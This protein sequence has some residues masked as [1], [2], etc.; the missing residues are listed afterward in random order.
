M[1]LILWLGP[2]AQTEV[3]SGLLIPTSQ[4][5]A[6]VC[7]KDGINNNVSCLWQ[8][9][10]GG[11]VFHRALH[12]RYLDYVRRNYS[13]SPL[14]S[15]HSNLHPWHPPLVSF[16]SNLSWSLPGGRTLLLLTQI[17]I[18]ISVVVLEEFIQIFHGRSPM[19]E[20]SRFKLKTQLKFL[21]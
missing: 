4:Q 10:V 12:D 11:I 21:E 19:G 17:A 9:E 1:F 2:W 13:L 8:V 14:V 5:A 6:Y 7:Y 15:F 20:P 16:H 18:K 3:R